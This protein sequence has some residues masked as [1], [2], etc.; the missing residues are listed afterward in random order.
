VDL[1]GGER[2]ARAAW[3][4]WASRPSS[5]AIGDELEAVGRD[6]RQDVAA[7]AAVGPCGLSGLS[8]CLQRGHVPEEIPRIPPYSVWH[9]LHWNMALAYPFGEGDE[10]L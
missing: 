10:L 9:R 1:T 2:Y 8:R 4:S 3:S 5:G 7:P 6:G